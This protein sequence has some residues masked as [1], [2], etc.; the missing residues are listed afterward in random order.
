MIRLIDT[1]TCVLTSVTVQFF[2]TRV[3]TCF[4]TSIETNGFEAGVASHRFETSVATCFETYVLDQCL[5][6]AVTA[7][8]IPTAYAAFT[9]TS[10][11]DE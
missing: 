5:L 3:A 6:A 11:H 10:L 7:H 1:E 9:V 2:K 8:D 4:K